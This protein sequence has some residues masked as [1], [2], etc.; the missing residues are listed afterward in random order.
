MSS[1]GAVTNTE[2]NVIFQMTQVKNQLTQAYKSEK[3]RLKNKTH[4]LLV[5]HTDKFAF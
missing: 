2:L 4:V 1:C 5:K 3:T